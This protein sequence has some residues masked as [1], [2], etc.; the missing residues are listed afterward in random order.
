[1]QCK[2]QFR[3]LGV[4]K[5]VSGPT[6]SSCEGRKMHEQEA[7]ELKN[8][9]RVTRCLGTRVVEPRAPFLPVLAS[10]QTY[11]FNLYCSDEQHQP[12][13]SLAIG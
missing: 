6:S 13:P 4:E 3:Q 5:E 2:C 7:I 8:A 10:H 1:L 9:K 11:S 12:P